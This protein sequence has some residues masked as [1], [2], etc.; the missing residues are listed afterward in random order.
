MHNNNFSTVVAVLTKH[1]LS[2]V[3]QQ[4]KLYSHL[5]WQILLIWSGKRAVLY[6]YGNTCLLLSQ[7]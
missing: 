3:I 2:V 4:F 5:N 6:V 7:C 1:E